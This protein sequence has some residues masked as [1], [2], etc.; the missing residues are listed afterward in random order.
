MFGTFSK[1]SA[2]IGLFC[3]FILLG[4]LYSFYSPC[5]N[6]GRLGYTKL[7]DSIS[8]ACTKKS[9][10]LITEG[11]IGRLLRQRAFFDHGCI[12]VTAK[13]RQDTVQIQDGP[14]TKQA[15]S[16]LSLNDSI[17]FHSAHYN[18]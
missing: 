15:T 10:A 11:I 9:L 13:Q 16:E 17:Y 18:I 4:K 1:L 6:D 2:V 3:R 14:K 8:L 5:D 7:Q 12:N